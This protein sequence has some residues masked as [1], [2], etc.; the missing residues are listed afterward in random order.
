MNRLQIYS[1]SIKEKST[2]EEYRWCQVAFFLKT[3]P[4]QCSLEISIFLVKIEW[5]DNMQT[6]TKLESII[7]KRMIEYFENDVRRI[8]H[9]LKVLGLA[10]AIAAGEDLGAEQYEIL[11]VSA[12]LHDIG[13][14]ESEKKYN[15]SSGKYQELEGPE[16]ARKLL[17]K[18]DLKKSFVERVCFLIGHHHTYTA[19]DKLDFQ[20]LV[21]AD[22]LVNIFEEEMKHNQIEYIYAKIFKTS[23]GIAILRSM[24]P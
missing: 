5:I 15:S 2:D 1:E 7:L 22:F 12:V 4:R 8:N 20:I 16:I 17:D 13:I 18:L 19:I 11:I 6:R 9:A 14:K 23:T 21:E 24:F 3:E 10:K